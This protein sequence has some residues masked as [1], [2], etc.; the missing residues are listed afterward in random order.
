[1]SLDDCQNKSADE[2]MA[3]LGH[4]LGILFPYYYII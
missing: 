2:T 3:C 4:P 1:M